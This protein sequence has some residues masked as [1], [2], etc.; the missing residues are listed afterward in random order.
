MT[1]ASAPE[2]AK[3]KKHSPFA[4]VIFRK[5]GETLDL[6]GKA[7]AGLGGFG[8]IAKAHQLGDV[9][10]LRLVVGLILGGA[11]VALG[12]YLQAKAEET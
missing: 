11:V 9:D 10:W 2:A 1:E 8:L 12:I 4:Q 7:V 5:L 6:G 3:P